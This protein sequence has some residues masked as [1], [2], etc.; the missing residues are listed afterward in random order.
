MG[1][2]CKKRLRHGDAFEFLNSEL[3][4]RGATIFILRTLSASFADIKIMDISEMQNAYIGKTIRSVL[5]LKPM[6]KNELISNVIKKLNPESPSTKEAKDKIVS[7]IVELIFNGKLNVKDGKIMLIG[8]FRTNSV[9]ED[10]TLKEHTSLVTQFINID[11][12]YYIE[13]VG[14]ER[15]PFLW[16]T[17]IP[18][19]QFK[20]ELIAEPSN[21]KDPN[22]VAVCIDKKPYAYLPREEA[23][24]YHR[25]LKSANANGVG[26]ETTATVGHYTNSEV[27]LFKLYLTGHE[28]LLTKILSS[29]K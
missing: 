5:S 28:E 22:A 2:K 1:L 16:S 14:S 13:T 19:M 6:D 18:G 15:Y 9:E 8:R 24:K 3:L 25:I 17:M 26:I 21:S 23:P 10:Y 11:G 4:G 27:K 29:K 20:V 7:V 12:G